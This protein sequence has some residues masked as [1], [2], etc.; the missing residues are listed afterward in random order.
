MLLDRERDVDTK[1]QRG[2]TGYTAEGEK[3]VP[4]SDGLFRKTAMEWLIATDQVR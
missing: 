2:I 3:F 1:V 4:Y